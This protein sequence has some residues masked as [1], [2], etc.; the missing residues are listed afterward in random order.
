MEIDFNFQRISGSS[1]L[2]N[3]KVTSVKLSG[4]TPITRVPLPHSPGGCLWVKRDDLTHSRYGGNKVRKLIPLLAKA[5]A[6]GKTSLLTVG[7]AGS[8]HVLATTVFGTQA[9]FRVKAVLT[10]RHFTEHSQEVLHTCLALGLEVTVAEHVSLLPGRVVRELS[11]EVGWI[12]AGGSNVLGASGYVQ[13][14]M[15]LAQQIEQGVLPAIDKVVVPLGTAGTAV[16]L[17]I[18]FAQKSLPIQVVGVYIAHPAWLLRASAKALAAQACRHYHLP[19]RKVW[20][21]LE[22]D[23]SYIGQGYGFPVT[24]GTAA[25]DLAIEHGIR[26]DETYTSKAMAAAI[27]LATQNPKQNILYWHTLSSASMTN[28]RN[29][30]PK[31][32]DITRFDHLLERLIRI[33]CLPIHA[34]KKIPFPVKSTT[35]V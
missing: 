35:W 7:A 18:G 16:G 28:L 14:A 1:L 12:P 25:T 4:P 31:N 24:E 8:H 30:A 15:E 9:G 2:R 32:Q 27:K 19:I 17:A 22:E 26:L 13:A 20:S 23:A 21:M 33:K 3:T 29:G 10:P 6:Q 34:I 5:K 11:P